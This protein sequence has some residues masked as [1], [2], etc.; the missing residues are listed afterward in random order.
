MVNKSQ[1]IFLCHRGHQEVGPR[2]RS[3]FADNHGVIATIRWRWRWWW[4]WWWRRDDG[5]HV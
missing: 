5:Q 3:G 4:R 2:S 1:Q